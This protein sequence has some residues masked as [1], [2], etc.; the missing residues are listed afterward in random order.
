MKKIISIF[1]AFSLMIAVISCGG[2]KEA[3]QTSQNTNEQKT[4]SS[5]SQKT[6]TKREFFDMKYVY[7]GVRV[8]KAKFDEEVKNIREN[9]EYAKRN[10]DFLNRKFA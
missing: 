7:K 1:T 8:D 9:D 4:A 6:E 2:N 5:D 3:N 10:F